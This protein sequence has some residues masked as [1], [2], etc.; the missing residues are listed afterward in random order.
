MKRNTAANGTPNFIQVK[1]SMEGAPGKI[2][3][4]W[5]MK[6]PFGGVPMIVAIPPILAA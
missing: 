5:V 4:S 1:K 6:I 2:V 3:A